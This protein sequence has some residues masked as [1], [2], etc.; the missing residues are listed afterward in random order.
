MI[1]GGIRRPANRSQRCFLFFSA[2]RA[3]AIS[4]KRLRPAA[5][6][7]RLDGFGAVC[8]ATEFLALACGLTVFLRASHLARRASAILFLEAALTLRHPVVLACF[9]PDFFSGT[10][11]EGKA[12]KA[13]IA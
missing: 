5:V 3:F 1:K 8:F 7:P 4:D 2:Q 9:T 10:A 6:M 13:A 11:V 12:S